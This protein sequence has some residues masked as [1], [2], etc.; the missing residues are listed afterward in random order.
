M[1]QDPKQDLDTGFEAAEVNTVT[2]LFKASLKMFFDNFWQIAFLVT[3]ICLPVELIK[4]ILL[5]GA[6]QQDNW[7]IT[8]TVESFISAVISPL[9]I[10]SLVYMLIYNKKN[11]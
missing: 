5:F 2:T 4:N 11:G 1:T 10:P 9:L 7:K 8:F 6:N 3:V